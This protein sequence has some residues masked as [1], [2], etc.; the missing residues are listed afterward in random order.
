MN[1]KILA[2]LS[3]I[4]SILLAVVVWVL[5][6]PRMLWEVPKDNYY[7]IAYNKIFVKYT[8]NKDG[9]YTIFYHGKEKTFTEEEFARKVGADKLIK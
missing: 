6:L 1:K 3:I 9:T 8:K 4:P 7:R 5:F 2:T